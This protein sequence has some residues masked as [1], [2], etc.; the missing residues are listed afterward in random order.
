MPTVIFSIYN[1]RLHLPGAFHCSSP[2]N[3]HSKLK[4]LTHVLVNNCYPNRKANTLI[5]CAIDEWCRQLTSR[6]A[7][8]N[9]IQLHYRNYTSSE[10]NVYKNHHLQER[11]DYRQG[12]DVIIHNILQKKTAQ[13]FIKNR[14]TPTPAPLREGYVIYEHA[15]TI[16]DCGFQAY[17]G[18]K[19]TKPPRRLTC[20]LQSGSIKNHCSAQHRTPLTR[21][22]L[23]EGMKII[24]SEKD[25]HRLMFLEALHITDLE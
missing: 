3:L 7:N 21:H 10:Y 12:P 14:Q 19:R 15:F 9:K 18:M 22:V 11:Q 25:P 23:E 13:L 5:N 2:K 24:D 20:H 16:K 1:R 4:S 17:T 6:T 8:R